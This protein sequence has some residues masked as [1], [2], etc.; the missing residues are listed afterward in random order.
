MS[1]AEL[2]QLSQM[3]LSKLKVAKLVLVACAPYS[4]LLKLALVD[5]GTRMICLRY[6]A[7]TLTRWQLSKVTFAAESMLNSESI[8]AFVASTPARKP[9]ATW[10]SIADKETPV[11]CRR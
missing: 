8:D 10:T 6:H 2:L 11:N 9:H 3:R 4:S 1:A 7:W 5:G